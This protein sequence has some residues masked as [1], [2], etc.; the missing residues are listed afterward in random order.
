MMRAAEVCAFAHPEALLTCTPAG[1]IMIFGGCD[2][3][4]A[5]CGDLHIFN[6]EGN[7]WHQLEAKGFANQYIT[8]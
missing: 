6:I 1:L 7:R 4:G 3:K 2:N 8:C 5:F